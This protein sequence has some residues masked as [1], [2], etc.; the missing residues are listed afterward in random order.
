MCDKKHKNLQMFGLKI[1]QMSNFHS[2]EIVGR[3]SEKQLQVS[4]KLN[5]FT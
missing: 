2:L 4:E 1:K 3:C 5:K